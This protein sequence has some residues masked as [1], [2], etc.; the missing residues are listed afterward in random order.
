MPQYKRIDRSVFVQKRIDRWNIYKIPTD[1]IRR[2]YVE[3]PT[4]NCFRR[5]YF[6][7]FKKT[8]FIILNL[9]SGKN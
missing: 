2:K 9:I 4:A 5:Y 7:N 3:I 8:I 1:P 6:F